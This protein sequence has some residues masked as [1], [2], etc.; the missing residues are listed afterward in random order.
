[1]KTKPE[2]RPLMEVKEQIQNVKVEV[3]KEIRLN[4]QYNVVV[5]YADIVIDNPYLESKLSLEMNPRSFGPSE[6]VESRIWLSKNLNSYWRA[7]SNIATVDGI[8]YGD[9]TRYFPR[10][11][12]AVIVSASSYFRESGRSIRQ[13]LYMLSASKT[14]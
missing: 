11:N 6:I 13:S 4:I 9:I 1:M 7:N 2:M 12:A 14:F 8:S 10:Q 3:N 5:N